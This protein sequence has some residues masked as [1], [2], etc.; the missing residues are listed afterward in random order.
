MQDERPR[1]PTANKISHATQITAVIRSCDV[2]SC[3]LSSKQT[4]FPRR[5]FFLGPGS[6]KPGVHRHYLVPAVLHP[7]TPEGA[8]ATLVS[9]GGQTVSILVSMGVGLRVGGRSL[10]IGPWEDRHGNLNL[11]IS[12]SAAASTCKPLAAAAAAAASAADLCHKDS[13]P[14]TVPTLV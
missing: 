9:A 8:V 6:H 11:E 10:K 3:K 5:V 2:Q 14:G 12:G 4:I 7:H 1:Y 13:N